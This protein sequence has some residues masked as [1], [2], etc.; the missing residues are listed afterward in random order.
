MKKTLCKALQTVLL[1]AVML[2]CPAIGQADEAEDLLVMRRAARV[3]NEAT[4]DMYRAFIKDVEGDFC[5]SPYVLYKQLPF[6]LQ[7]LPLV[8]RKR[9]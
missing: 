5:F 2:C 7:A 6:L 8:W 9:K 1:L 4:F 3:I